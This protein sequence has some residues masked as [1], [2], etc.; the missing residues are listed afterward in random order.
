MKLI[1]IFATCLAV[2]GTACAYNATGPVTYLGSQSK[3][4]SGGATAQGLVYTSGTTPSFNGSIVEGGIKNQT[5]Q[6]IKNI[7]V[8]LEEAGTS[9]ANILKCTVFLADIEDYAAMNEVYQKMLPY[10]KP[11]RTALQVAKLP[12]DFLVEIEAIAAIPYY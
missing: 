7:E 5:A 4:L 1:S 9:L 2:A 6:I 8:V 10:P 3:L 12:G 11:A